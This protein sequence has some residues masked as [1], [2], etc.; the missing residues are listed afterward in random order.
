M[1]DVQYMMYRLCDSYHST[2]SPLQYR[3]MQKNGIQLPQDPLDPSRRVG[4]SDERLRDVLF[5][6]NSLLTADN[7]TA[8]HSRSS[9]NGLEQLLRVSELELLRSGEANTHENRSSVTSSVNSPSQEDPPHCDP[10][11]LFQ[12]TEQS[13]DEVLAAETLSSLASIGSGTIHQKPQSLKGKEA[14]KSVSSN[15]DNLNARKRSN[16]RTSTSS[17]LPSFVLAGTS[18]PSHGSRRSPWRVGM[19]SIRVPD[20]NILGEGE[21]AEDRYSLAIEKVDTG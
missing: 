21:E 1:Y 6:P 4:S 12:R 7:H 17:H 18:S 9:I 5:E 16:S 2:H 8:N 3:M 14:S 11:P 19:N 15:P 10:S 13:R 20:H